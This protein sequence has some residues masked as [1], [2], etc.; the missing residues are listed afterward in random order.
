MVGEHD[1]VAPRAN[2]DAIAA[3]WSGTRVMEIAGA[4]HMFNIEKPDEVNNAIIAFLKE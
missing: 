2:S 4:G 3:A 1:E